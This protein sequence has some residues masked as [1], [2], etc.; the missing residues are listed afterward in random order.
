[1]YT[2]GKHYN[3]EFKLLALVFVYL[4]LNTLSFRNIIVGMKINN[5]I[6]YIKEI[7]K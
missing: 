6:I 4:Q 5:W 1:M 3:Q 7:E 2:F